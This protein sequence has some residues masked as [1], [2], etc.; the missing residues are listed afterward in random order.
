MNT[1]SVRLALLAAGCLGL[2]AL[3][4]LAAWPVVQI[5][6]P[7]VADSAVTKSA[8]NRAPKISADSVAAIAF[9]DPFRVGRRPALP[10]YDPLRLA[11]QLA[12]PPPRPALVL[13][14]VTDGAMA[15]AVIEGLPGVEGARVVRVGDI[16][17]GLAIKKMGGGRVVITGMDTTWVLEVREPWKN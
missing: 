16:I 4:R 13:V 9:R 11:Q 6:L 1:K 5:R 2:I 8:V 15:S 7:P 10:A 3:V 12:P 17:G 14:G